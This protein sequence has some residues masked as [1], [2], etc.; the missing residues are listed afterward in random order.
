MSVIRFDGEQSTPKI[1]GLSSK[2]KS[3]YVNRRMRLECSKCAAV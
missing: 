2:N 1:E 3:D